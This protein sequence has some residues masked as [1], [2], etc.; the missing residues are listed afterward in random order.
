MLMSRRFALPDFPRVER[1]ASDF[2]FWHIADMP[3]LPIWVRFWD[4]S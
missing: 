4:L 2:R 1:A 3:R